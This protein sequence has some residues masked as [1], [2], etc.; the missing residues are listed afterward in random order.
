MK[1]RNKITMVYATF[2][3]VLA[4]VFYTNAPEMKSNKT[5][6]NSKKIEAVR[7]L[8]SS[9]DAGVDEAAQLEAKITHINEEFARLSKEFAP[10][11]KEEKELQEM[12]I[13]D[14]KELRDQVKEKLPQEQV[15]AFRIAYEEVIQMEGV[16]KSKL[17]SQEDFEILDIY[18]YNQGIDKLISDKAIAIAERAE[19]AEAEKA[20][21]EEEERLAAEKAKKEEE[22]RLAAEKAKKEEEERL[23]AE[24]K[25]EEEEREAEEE[26]KSLAK[27][28]DKLEKENKKLKKELDDEKCD[29]YST[30]S[31]LHDIIGK[32]LEDKYG[33][34]QEV[35]RQSSPM[36]YMAFFMMQMFSRSMMAGSNPMSGFSY[37][38]FATELQ[39]IQRMRTIGFKA[40]SIFDYQ[41]QVFSLPGINSFPNVS[42]DMD[43]SRSMHGLNGRQ[44]AAGGPIIINNNNNYGGGMDFA[45]RNPSQYGGEGHDMP[46]MIPQWNRGDGTA[47]M[48]T[49]RP[50]KA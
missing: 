10:F 12:S 18:K 4:I 49:Q 42:T 9:D 7:K 30:L 8:S 22:E 36:D 44:Q 25:K 1:T 32:K 14:L 20:K 24:K 19:I 27:R 23:A 26:E 50:D 17:P 16:D 39:T 5:T 31:D 6:W 37:S 40:P 34:V 2:V 28:L 3:L 13:K 21:K 46:Q 43:L 15:D 48:F 47:K 45:G 11:S 38:P 35:E 33:V 29:S 41:D